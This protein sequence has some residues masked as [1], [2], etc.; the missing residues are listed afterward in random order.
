MSG[1]SL[2]YSNAVLFVEKTFTPWIEG[3]EFKERFVSPYHLIYHELTNPLRFGG[4]YLP[5]DEQA[6][7]LVDLARINAGVYDLARKICRSNL[8][9]QQQ[10]SGPLLSFVMEILSDTLTRPKAEKR[11]KTWYFS[12]NKLFAVYL[13]ALKFDLKHT[14]GDNNSPISACDAVVEGLA[15]CGRHVGYRDVKM[16]VVEKRYMRLRQEAELL[17]S[18]SHEGSGLTRFSHI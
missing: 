18:L 1:R 8:L 7:E 11:E 10:L 13:T 6:Q 5:S 3:G 15:R 4:V 2:S 12:L 16:L 14:R 17:V 9:R